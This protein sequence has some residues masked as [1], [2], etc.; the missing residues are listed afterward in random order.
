MGWSTFYSVWQTSS[1]RTF[2]VGTKSVFN[3]ENPKICTNHTVIDAW[4]DGDLA[5]K[6][7][8]AL[9][10][11]AG[12]GI[13]GVIQG[14]LMFTKKDVKTELFIVKNYIHLD[15]ILSPMVFL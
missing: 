13:E 4:Y 2:F 7:H 12:L 14:D 8:M 9:N 6:L 11:F 10:M 1:Y 3:K 15:L 5:D